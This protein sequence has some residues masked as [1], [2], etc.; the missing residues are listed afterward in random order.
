[1]SPGPVHGTRR[2]PEIGILHLVL[3]Q[4]DLTST[5][6]CTSTFKLTGV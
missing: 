5:D 4:D 6:T 3:E 1:V 2:E